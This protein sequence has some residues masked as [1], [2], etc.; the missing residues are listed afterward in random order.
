M[1]SKVIKYQFSSF[2]MPLTKAKTSLDIL[3]YLPELDLGLSLNPLV[4]VH[5]SLVCCSQRIANRN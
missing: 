5:E 4:S 3:D 2:K 1:K